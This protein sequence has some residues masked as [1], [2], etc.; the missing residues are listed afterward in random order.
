MTHARPLLASFLLFSSSAR[1]GE[2]IWVEA[3]HLHGVRGSCFPDMGGKTAGHWALSGPGIAP[4]WTQGGESEWLSIACSPDD[5]SASASIEVE[6]PEAGTWTLW[7]RY[8]DWR[9]ETEIFG[10]RVEQPGRPAQQFVFGE[11]PVVDEEDE[12]KILWKWAFGWQSK[13]V[14]LAKGP[15]TLTLLSHA[16][17][18][19]HRQVDCFC[20][21]TDQTYRPLHREK[22]DRPV[23]KFLAG[24]RSDPKVAPTPLSPR[25]GDFSVPSAWKP[26]M[27]RDQG[28][29]YLWNVG[30][31]WE[32]DLASADPKRVLFPYST[33]PV[34]VAAFRAAF[35]GRTDVP[36]FSD[37]RI[38]PVFHG[39][40]PNILENPH[41]VKWLESNPQRPWGNMMN[42]IEPKPLTPR[43]LTNWTRFKDRY[44]GNISGE[45]LGHNVPYDAKALAARVKAAKSREEVLAAYTEVFAAGVVTKQTTV[46]GKAEP[47]PYRGFIP[48]QSSDAPTFAHA[49]REWGARTVGYENT[50]NTPGLAMRLAFLRGGARQ[51]GGLWATYRSCNFGDAS[52]IFSEQSTYAHP[53]HAYDNWYDVWAG[54]GM[55]WY[56][57]DLWHQYLSGSSMFYHEQGFDEFWTPGGGSTPRKPIQLSPKGRLVEHFLE[58]TRKHPDRGTPFTPIAFLLDRAHGWDPNSFHPSYFGL[59]ISAN[60]K[61]L[62]FGSHARMLKEWFQTAYYPYGPKEAEINTALNQNYFASPMGA[63][64]DVLVTSPTKMDAIDLYPVVVLNGE[65]TLS[66]AWGKKLADYVERGGTLIVSDEQLTG[67]GMAELK[68]PQLGAVAE[69]NAV[70]WQPTS[71]QV[72]S[73]R[74][75]FRPIL[76]GTPLAKSSDGGVVAATFDRGKGRLVF[77]SVPCG[78]GIDGAAT[79]L[80]ALVLAHAR[81]GLLPIEVEGEVEWLLNR[82]ATGWLVG[83]FNPAGNTRLQHGVGP[84]DYRKERT[85]AIRSPLNITKTSEWFTDEAQGVVAEQ[86]GRWVVKIAVPA[87]GVRIIQLETAKSANGR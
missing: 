17:Q 1:G 32:D 13:G 36:I 2:T 15:A 53:K 83:L 61:V 72:A 37:P 74:Y 38:V 46:F 21:T 49:A 34:Q 45:S 73:Q 70:H 82:T 20:L 28:F 79:P 23:W 33:E 14:S 69:S 27:F 18:K 25:A 35:G 54:A 65:I 56:K 80:V 78:L 85:V 10:V 4:E 5:D 50:A 57:F 48:C 11:R 43:A 71:K 26:A 87:G 24:L 44:V 86:N 22:P 76:G 6:V 55:T 81:Q 63:V 47:E 59:E 40:G 9:N 64:F 19:S 84:T 77:L 41:F 16:K 66:S 8:R 39:G 7:V 68:L 67:P 12:L 62:L 52:T 60:P 75:R 51:Y 42:Y 31:P 29:L 30:K 58:V 3:E